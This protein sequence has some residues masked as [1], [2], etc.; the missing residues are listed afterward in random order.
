MRFQPT[1][2]NIWG[3]TYPLIFA[4]ISETVIDV[5]DT[6]FL[7]HYGTTELA[8]IGVADAVYGLSLFLVVG[9]VEATQ[10]MIGRRAGQARPVMLGRVF[11][12]GL[13]LL[14]LSAAVMIPMILFAAPVLLEYALADLSLAHTAFDYLRIAAFALLFQAL[15]MVISAF[16]IG[17]SR[18]R[19][20]IAASLVLAATNITLDSVLIFGRLGFPE[21]GISGAA[22]ATLSAEAATT[23]LL[24]AYLAW[25][26]YPGR[27]GLFRFTGWSASLAASVTRLALPGAANSLVD[28][29]KWFALLVII[30][31]AGEVPLAGANIVLACYSLLLIPVESFSETVCSMVS[32]L[33]GQRRQHEM[34]TLSGRTIRLA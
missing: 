8:A 15:N 7:A 14:V 11:N 29:A 21:L 31:K 28:M 6:V 30:E 17:V 23:L 12:L 13:A 9:L 20:L 24:L 2:G 1:Y 5:T 16:L 4:G 22:I 32:N 26:R 34:R 10:I 18:T 27:F 25:R 19:V 33:I 3:V